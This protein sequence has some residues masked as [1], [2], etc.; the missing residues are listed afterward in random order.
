MAITRS[1]FGELNRITSVVTGPNN[2]N[3][4][5]SDALATI[6]QGSAQIFWWID[7]TVSGIATALNSGGQ[8]VLQ[9]VGTKALDSES[10]NEIL[11]SR[12][13]DIDHGSFVSTDLGLD[14]FDSFFLR[15]KLGGILD[16][17]TNYNNGDFI[18]QLVTRR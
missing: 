14:L 5:D 9:V 8:I 11:W 12:D 6:W 7:N 16:T 2:R 4:I 3:D 10:F 13:I 15:L 1:T 18:V 17:A